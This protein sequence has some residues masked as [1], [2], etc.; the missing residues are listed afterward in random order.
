MPVTLQTT[1][2]NITLKI[3]NKENAKVIQTYYEFMKGSGNSERH[4]KNNLKCMTGFSVYLCNKL[5]S[6][7][8]D[9][10]TVLQFLNSKQKP[11]DEDPDQRWIT[12]W[13]D[14]LGRIKKFYRWFQNQYINNETNSSD[15]ITPHFVQI[16]NKLTRRISPYLD[17]E[18][19]DMEEISLVIKYEQF[20]RNKAAL[21]LM[22][23]LDA[24]N[25]EIT[26]L[27]I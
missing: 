9:R 22:W 21:A 26:L 16:K 11:R 18:L 12:T 10:E 24:R 27:K 4:Q 2:K 25:H 20:K 14:Y 23:D 13:N 15:W 17:T 1:I 7:V 8:N 5:L 3:H 6:E 19:W